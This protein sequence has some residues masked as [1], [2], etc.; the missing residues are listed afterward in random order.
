MLSP[1]R[2]FNPAATKLKRERSRADERDFF[3]L[4]V[5]QL[6][7]GVARVVKTVQDKCFLVAGV[8]SLAQSVMACGDAARQRANAGVREKN[9]VSRDRKFVLAQF[10]VG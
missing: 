9:F 10:F 7:A 8:P 3:R 2:N 1:L 4:A 6:R 5:Q